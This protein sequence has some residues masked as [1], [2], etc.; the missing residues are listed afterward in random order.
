MSAANRRHRAPGAAPTAPAAAMWLRLVAAVALAAVGVLAPAPQALADA[1]GP[2][3]YRTDIVSIDPETS[4]IHV[5]MIGGDAFLRLE[6]LEPVEVTVLGYQGEPYLRFDPDGTVYEN[7]RS[8]A[9]WLNQERYG[10]DKPPAFAN[11]DARPEWF[12]VATGGAYAWHDH[13]SHWMNPQR[14]PGARAGDQ[15]LEATVPIVVDDTRVTITVASYLLAD[16]S[17]LPSVAGAAVGLA[18]AAVA[19]RGARSATP[20]TGL[21]AA[22]PAALVGMIA[23]RSVPPETQPSALLWVLPV[24]TMAAALTWVLAHRRVATTVYLDGLLV[25]AGGCLTAWS[26][27]RFDALRRALIPSDAPGW[28][29]RMTITL[30]LVI[31]AAVALRGAFGLVRP[32]RLERGV[33]PA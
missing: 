17:P 27:T 25:V 24:V 16:P 14:P 23:F 1:A 6:Q 5:E 22:G 20:L 2:T 11:P 26:I 32:S 28:L 15:I 31:G 7:R 12:E 18:G 3:D 4:T 30:A 9:V 8:P 10:D 19:I 13:R 29:D 21:L 33:V